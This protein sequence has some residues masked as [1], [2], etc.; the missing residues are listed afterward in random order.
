MRTVLAISG[1][2]DSAVLL[3]MVAKKTLPSISNLQDLVL[4][5]NDIIVA[6][7]DH[8]IRENT[9]DVN[10]IKDL[11]D[12]YKMK[13]IVGY[14]HLGKEASEQLARQKRY[15]FLR[16]VADGGQIITAHHQDDL[17]ETIVMNLIRGTGWRGLSPFWSNDISRPLLNMS[18]VEIVNYAIEN[19]LDWVE[20]ETNY[21]PQY[22][23]NRIRD[24]IVKIPIKQKQQLLGLSQKQANSRAKIEKILQD[25]VLQE[26]SYKIENITKLADDLAIE[27]LR[28]ITDGK[29][30]IPQMKRLLENLKTSK[31]GD[32]FQPGGKMQ[33]AVYRGNF[34]ISK[35]S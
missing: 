12:K 1:G 7:F 5:R 3:D 32:I 26:N 27:I 23:R 20:D 17:L 11:A 19:D 18:K 2:V 35:L 29:L 34:T 15:E 21:S 16:E 33:I 22:F 14:G 28:K 13:Y 4:L 8:G 25:L 30:T 10:F 9:N 6:H 24:S 31:S